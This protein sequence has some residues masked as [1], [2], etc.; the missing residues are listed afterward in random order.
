MKISKEN[1]EELDRLIEMSK[2]YN[3]YLDMSLEKALKITQENDNA[4]YTFDTIMNRVW[5]VDGLM[6]VLG[7]EV[8]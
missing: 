2:L 4:G 1:Y 3:K 5:E 7:I 6:D 8:E